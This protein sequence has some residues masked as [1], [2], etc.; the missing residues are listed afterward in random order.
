MKNY[1]RQ[2]TVENIL[3]E[4]RMDLVADWKINDHNAMIE[5]FKAKEVFEEMFK[6]STD[7]MSIINSKGLLQVTDISQIENIVDLQFIRDS[8]LKCVV[9]PMHGA[10]G[11]FFP[12]L[13]GNGKTTIHEI[14]GEQNPAFPGMHN[15][16]PVA[17]NLEQLRQTIVEQK[18]DVGL[19][20][21]GDAGD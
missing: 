8:G 14:R 4:G 3:D 6:S 5:K 11:G 7:P 15:P 13:V 18:A 16:E 9:D 21:D 19:A 2:V 10:G 1:E 12:K 17:H 20:M